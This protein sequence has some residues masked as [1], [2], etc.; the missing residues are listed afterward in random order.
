MGKKIFVSYKY[1]DQDVAPLPGHYWTTVRS[2]VDELENFL[3]E[4]TTSIKENQMMKISVGFQ[5]MPYGKN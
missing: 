1:A 3:I 4:Q 2:Y 5:K